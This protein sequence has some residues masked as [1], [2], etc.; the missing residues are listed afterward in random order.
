MNPKQVTE[1]AQ[2]LA[3]KS[4]DTITRELRQRRLSPEESIAV[5]HQ[6]QAQTGE[7]QLNAGLAS[8]NAEWQQEQPLQPQ[9]EIGRLMQKAGIERSRRYTIDELA[10]LLQASPL[11][12][13]ERLACKIEADMLGLLRAGRSSLQAGREM[14]ASAEKIL[15]DRH[16]NPVTLRFRP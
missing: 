16:G 7:R 5:R 6:I 12:T 15:R 10:A 4:D 2:D 3:G 8:D 14:H 11:T 1:L 9:T 13:E